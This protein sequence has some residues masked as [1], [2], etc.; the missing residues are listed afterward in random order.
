M[1]REQFKCQTN[2]AVT[3]HDVKQWLSD[4]ETEAWSKMDENFNEITDLELEA[5]EIEQY[6][7][8]GKY[9]ITSLLLNLIS[10]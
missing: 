7:N 6:C 10:I 8:P 3:S 1:K 5:N 2:S 9:S 4:V